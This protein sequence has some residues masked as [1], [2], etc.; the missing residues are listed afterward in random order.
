MRKR[1]WSTAALV[2]IAAVYA[3]VMVHWRWNGT[4]GEAWR[5]VIYSD[6]KGYYGYLRAVFSTHDLGHEPLD[7][8]YLHPKDGVFPEKVNEGRSMV[9]HTPRRIGDNP[10]PSALKFSGRNT[11]DA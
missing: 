10:N 3:V 11:F 4:D 1:S 8:E 2:V 9:G 5:H 6:A 7:T